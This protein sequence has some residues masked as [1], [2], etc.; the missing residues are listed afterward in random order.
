[1]VT[2]EELAAAFARNFNIVKSQTNG[3]THADSLLQ[4]PFRGN[5]LNWVLGHI[6]DTRNGVL[7][8]LGEMPVLS[9]GDRAR[10]YGHGSEPVCSD[11]EG[12]LTLEQLL[13]KLESSQSAIEAGLKRISPEELARETRDHR[14]PVTVGQR[15]FFLYFHETYH[16]GQTELLRQLAGTND[17]VI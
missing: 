1:M 16:V 15:L 2:P 4:P 6:L 13:K 9:E 3:L 14:G 7:K 8:V 11:G 5:C 12:V 17:H 10:P